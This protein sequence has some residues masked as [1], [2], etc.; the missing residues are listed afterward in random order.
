MLRGLLQKIQDAINI[1]YDNE[2]EEEEEEEVSEQ[3]IL[4]SESVEEENF[5]PIPTPKKENEQLLLYYKT[6]KK[7]SSF[8]PGTDF[9][10]NPS[11]IRHS[12]NEINQNIQNLIEEQN[13][14]DLLY[15]SC[16]SL[17]SIE[18]EITQLRQKSQQLNQ[19]NKTLQNHINN[20]HNLLSSDQLSQ[21]D[22]D[23]ATQQLQDLRSQV[24][25][26]TLSNS[27][28]QSSISL[29]ESQ[30][31]S[32]S[33][34]NSSIQ[35][36]LAEERI[37]YSQ[38]MSEINS[39]Q[40]S[41]SSSDR[42]GS[43]SDVSLLEERLACGRSEL[44]RLS[45]IA[46]DLPP[47]EALESELNSLVDTFNEMCRTKREDAARAESE[48]EP[49]EAERA[50]ITDLLFAHA[51]GDRDSLEKLR[52]AFAWTEEEMAALRDENRGISGFM[53]KGARMFCRFRDL[54]TSWLISASE[55]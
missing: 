16:R 42:F 32:N 2:E 35:S 52:E 43:D 41:P 13:R 50:E 20:L 10:T 23:S 3:D 54:W 17:T 19:S 11:Q 21:I 40:S 27:Q 55:E 22:K 5:D 37:L 24:E 39:F 28:L 25:S 38:I 46:V 31:D 7:L 34:M 49:A 12:I 44:E 47:V 6:V 26:K 9:V 14:L 29:L 15:D 51:R 33:K 53:R 45:A 4:G 30:L 18:Q 8:F 1:E 48:Q 36:E